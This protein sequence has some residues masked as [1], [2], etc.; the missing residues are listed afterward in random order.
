MKVYIIHITA[1]VL[2]Q[3]YKYREILSP[4][5]KQEIALIINH[6][7]KEQ[8]LTS[9][10]MKRYFLSFYCNY[11]VLPNEW[12]FDA[13]INNK[14]FL[15]N[16]FQKTNINF[17]VSHCDNVFAIAI[18]KGFEVG[19]D[20]E[21]YS[22]LIDDNLAK[23]VF[24]E[25][26]IIESKKYTLIEKQEYLLRLW[27]L[28]EAYAKYL[29]LGINIDFKAINF[30][31]DDNTYFPILRNR[32]IPAIIIHNTNVCF[33]ESNYSLSIAKSR[34]QHHS[35]KPEIIQLNNLKI[36]NLLSIS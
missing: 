9:K 25:N 24:S 11:K 22:F 14:P 7:V 8:M 28:K 19:L 33:S 18:T 32:E 20:I 30:F 23:T 31:N 3:I 10:I 35:A 13:T 26:E 5:E 29:G 17:N 16:G 2:S 27:T 34:K 6:K 12:N 15:S 36:T 4:E 1:D 21:S